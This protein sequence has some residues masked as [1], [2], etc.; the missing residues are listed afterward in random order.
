[1]ARDVDT[2]SLVKGRDLYPR[3]LNRGRQMARRPFLEA[4]LA[5][6]G[7]VVDVRQG[8]LEFDG[9]DYR[10]AVRRYWIAHGLS[11]RY[12]CESAMSNCRAGS[13]RF[14]R[15]PPSCGVNALAIERG[16]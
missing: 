4:A 5:P 14:I 6:V 10:N 1:V 2:L 15:C 9:D 8:Y 11:S 13:T 7:A 12:R 16:A 3:L